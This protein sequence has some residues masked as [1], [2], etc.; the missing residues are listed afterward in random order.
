[1]NLSSGTIK[2]C[3]SPAG[4]PFFAPGTLRY[5]KDCP[6]CIY[7]TLRRVDHEHWQGWFCIDCKWEITDLALACLKPGEI[8]FHLQKFLPPAPTN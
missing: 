6:R 4:M 3:Y 1:M 8:G 7:G 2:N 5:E